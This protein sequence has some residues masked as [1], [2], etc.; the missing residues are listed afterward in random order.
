[1]ELRLI[2]HRAEEVFYLP[3][4][5]QPPVD[6]FWRGFDDSHPVILS[7]WLGE[8][9]ATHAGAISRRTG[10]GLLNRRADSIEPEPPEAR[11][12]THSLILHKVLKCRFEVVA[13]P[14]G[15]DDRQSI[16]QLLLGQLAL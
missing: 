9:R 5:V 3:G 2:D 16:V 4:Q 12:R 11:I 1:M 6:V 15:E 7:Y 13:Y 10:R 14:C 8:S